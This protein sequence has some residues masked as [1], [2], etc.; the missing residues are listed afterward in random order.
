MKA[1]PWILAGVGVGLV[2]YF[3][4]NQPGLQYATGDPDVEDAADR[5]AFW[6]SKQRV[7][8]AGS[9]VFGKVKEGV[10]RVTGDDELAGEG[11]GDQLAGAVKDAAGN[12]AQAAGNVL[13]EINR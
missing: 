8:G 1:L 13:H 2:T 11:A 12:V 7:S 6:G 4:L 9:S 5:T 10:G 3:A